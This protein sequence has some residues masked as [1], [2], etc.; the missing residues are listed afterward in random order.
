VVNLTTVLL[1]TVF[2][3]YSVWRESMWH[4]ERKDLYNRLM[5]KDLTE[6]RQKEVVVLPPKAPSSKFITIL[7]K[8]Q[9][10]G[11]D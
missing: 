6:Y 8:S 9:E 1:I 11:G 3:A 7:H 10:K 4:N 2:L 5:A